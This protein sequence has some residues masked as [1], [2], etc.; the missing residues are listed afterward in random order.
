[1]Q[2][3][4][5]A[6]DDII[7]AHVLSGDANLDGTVNLQDFNRLAAHFGESGTTWAEGNFNYD[8]VTNLPDFN[9][10]AGNFGNSAA[11]DAAPSAP[12]I[13]ADELLKMLEQTTAA[14]AT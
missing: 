5:L 10:L 8:N 11:P 4:N 13:S 2:G 14:E 6:A 7:I 3:L 12:G 1:V 9:A